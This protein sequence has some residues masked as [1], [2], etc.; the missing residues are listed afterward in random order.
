MSPSPVSAGSLKAVVSDISQATSLNCQ[1]RLN[2][3]VV[4]TERLLR[5][6][7]VSYSPVYEFTTVT[8]DT[9][10]VYDLLVDN[11]AA[12]AS[13]KAFTVVVDPRI[14]SLVIPK[15]V[16]PGDGV[17]ME[18]KTR[19]PS[20][21][22]TYQWMR[23]SS[24]VSSGS[25]ATA[26]IVSGGTSAVMTIK[27]VSAASEGNYYVV[28]SKGTAQSLTSG[29]VHMS[30]AAPVSIETQP[31]LGASLKVGG[32][33]N[34]SVGASGGGTLTYQWFRDGAALVDSGTSVV[35]GGTSEVTGATTSRLRIGKVQ[36]K[37]AGVYQVRVANAS[38]SKTS[39]LVTVD[40]LEPLGVEIEA[41]SDANPAQRTLNLGE[42]VNFVAKVTGSGTIALQWNHLVGDVYQPIKG[43]TGEQYRINPA[44][45]ADAGFYTLTA[46]ATITSGTVQAV[47]TVTSAPV[48]LV[49]KQVP[50]I[51]VHPVSV[52]V[53]TSGSA[54]VSAGFAVVA[55][56]APLLPL[57]YQWYKD[58]AAVSGATSSVLRL[59]DVRGSASCEYRVR[60]SNSDG[61]VETS[62]KLNVLTSGTL[63]ET[64]NAGAPGT[65]FTPTAWWVYWTK[66]TKASNAL[67]SLSGY[68]LLE[69]KLAKDAGSKVTAVTPGKAVWILGSTASARTVSALK[70]DE[71]DSDYITTQDVSTSERGEFSAVAY[72]A[73]HQ[74]N[75]TLSGRVQSGGDAAL[76][77]A[78]E[79]M[80]GDYSLFVDGADGSSSEDFETDLSWDAEQTMLLGAMD[81]QADV[82]AA[83]KENL[84]R[85]FADIR[86]E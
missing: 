23:G 71:W 75:F 32:D 63:P 15:S 74:T 69:R 12:F 42:G 7:T 84:L 33:L 66:A 68:W 34:L 28:V 46:T 62:A 26:D 27:A 21:D 50:V 41:L 38:G 72:H 40:V 31:A 39:D 36:S 9:D 29:T 17:T 85:E 2:G 8:N 6:G 49:V 79:V 11:G 86:G 78:P 65:A 57:S 18:V 19:N 24:A 5:S 22:Y 47:T 52:S 81:N 10:G 67:D 76:Y 43:A 56:S 37:E 58:G 54:A 3:T 13:S 73:V 14:E 35:S 59:A 45:M 16:N 25:L 20:S 53:I 44:T 77:G 82:E 61:S 51:L 83:L 70:T 60:V 64:S 80:A 1:W 30:V 4:K 48:K 55:R